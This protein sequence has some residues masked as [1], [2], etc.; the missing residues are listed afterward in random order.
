MAKISGSNS[1]S[2]PW[3]QPKPKK[4]GDA[5]DD[6]GKPSWLP[7]GAWDIAF[8]ALPQITGLA[9][10]TML[11]VSVVLF[12]LNQKH[13]LP[14]P[15]SSVVSKTLFWPT[16]PISVLKRLQ[17][18][19]TPIDEAVVMGGIPFGFLGMPERL[20]NEYNVSIHFSS[21]A[22]SRPYDQPTIYRSCVVSDPWSH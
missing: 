10:K 5:D 18:W 12:V 14:R 1:L 4:D 8:G 9:V 3:R 2:S 22:V 19:M 20:Y 17:A 21:S 13:M 16:L 11:G 6:D 15:L 7:S